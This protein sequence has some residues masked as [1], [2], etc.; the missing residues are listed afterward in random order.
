[1]FCVVVPGSALRRFVVPLTAE[2]IAPILVALA[3]AFGLSTPRQGL[4]SLALS[5]LILFP[6]KENNLG[7]DCQTGIL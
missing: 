7:I 5:H 6:R 3:L 2:K 1:M 4:P